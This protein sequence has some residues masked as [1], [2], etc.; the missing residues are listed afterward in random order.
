MP[1]AWA[2][3]PGEASPSSNA[4]TID[5]RAGSP[6]AACTRAR[7]STAERSADI[8]SM[9]AELMSGVKAEPGGRCYT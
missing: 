5:S 8:D 6:S 2:I 3:S 1:S 4:S 9:V 7:T